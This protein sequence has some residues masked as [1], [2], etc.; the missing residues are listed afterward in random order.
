MAV[1]PPRPLSISALPLRIAIYGPSAAGKTRFLT[2]MPE[3]I[4]IDVETALDAQAHDAPGVRKIDIR[5]AAEVV[6]A[7]EAIVE[8]RPGFECGS[9]GLDS[10]TAYR[11]LLQ[12]DPGRKK[13]GDFK[14]SDVNEKIRD[15]L[16]RVFVGLPMPICVTAHEKR[17]TDREKQLANHEGMIPDS[18]PRFMYAFDIVAR[19]VSMN[20]RRGAVIIKSRFGTIFPVQKFIPDFSYDY[21]VQGLAA[22]QGGDQRPAHGNGRQQGAAAAQAGGGQ[23]VRPITSAGDGALTP[24]QKLEAIRERYVAAGSPCGTFN[25]WLVEHRYPTNMRALLADR[26]A[27]A[28]IWRLLGRGQRAAS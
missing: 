18:D 1:N 20:G 11:R 22:A 28:Q 10:V 2:R 16:S 27:M 17:A 9:F 8:R 5:T 26:A 25:E 7:F 13:R 12:N 15:L 23:N 4:V 14:D 3:P 6:D 21:I 24:T 19:L